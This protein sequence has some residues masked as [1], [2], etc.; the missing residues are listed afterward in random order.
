MSDFSELCN[1]VE[2]T[3][4]ENAHDCRRWRIEIMD[5]IRMSYRTFGF[6]DFQSMLASAKAL[7]SKKRPS[8]RLFAY[9]PYDA[10][11]SQGAELRNLGFRS[12]GP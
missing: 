8:E 1:G 5:R 12:S 9:T 10:T 11:Y 3:S 2:L 4:D 7:M 6:R